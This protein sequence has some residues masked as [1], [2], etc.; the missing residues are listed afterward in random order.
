MSEIND[1]ATVTLNVNGAQAKRMMSELETKI[2]QTNAK[3]SS[4]KANMADPKDIEKAR[5]DLKTYQTQL[6]E[7][8]SAAAGVTKAL[9]NLDAATPR[10]IE[11]ALR[12]LNRQLKDMTPGTDVWN[13]HI[14]KIQVLK[15]RLADLK[16]GLETQES[17]WMKFR[18]W[19]VSAWPA[20]DILRQ[21]YEKLTGIVNE[22]VETYATMDSAMANTQKFT[23]MTRD[24]VESLNEEFKKMDTRTSREGLNELAQSAGRLGKQ[25]VEDVMGF[26]R[27]GDII[28]V[29]MDEL[30]S[31]APEI[32]SKLAGIFN[33]ES[34]M[35]TEK[36]ML[37]VG[38]AINSLTQ[39]YAA[40]AP[41]LVDFA[42]RMGAT[43]SQTNM[44]MHEML[45]FGTLLDANGVS[46]EKSAT[47][48]QGVISKMYATPKKFA[49][50]AGLDVNAFTEAL[51]RSSTEGVLMFVEALSK[52]DQMQLNATLK[53]LKIS[54]S[55]IT[56][57]F[58]TLA[59]KSQDLNRVLAES[60]TAFNQATSATEEY[61][62]Q[63]N[64]AQAKLDKIKKR[65]HD[66]QVEIGEKLY[67]LMGH[68]M[69]SASALSKAIL[70]LI[71]FM[72]ANKTA[73]VSLTAGVV[74]YYIAINLAAVKTAYFNVVSKAMTAVLGLQ[75]LGT[76]AMTGVIGLFTG[77]ITKATAAFKLFSTAIKAN[78]IGLIVSA[79]TTAIAALSSWIGKTNEAKRAEAEAAK[80]RAEAMNTFRREI[81]DYSKKASDYANGE[82]SRL[83]KLYSA[84][85]DATLSQKDRLAA[86]KRLQAAYPAT[87]ANL[88]NEEILT[89]RASKS[90]HAL[91]TNIMKVAKAKAAADLIKDNEKLLLDLEVENDLLIESITSDSKELDRAKYNRTLYG[92]SLSRDYSLSLLGPPASAKETLNRMDSVVTN[93]GSKIDKAGET[94]E[95]NLT[96]IGEIRD[97]N[98]RLAKKAESA[99]KDV[100]DV[101]FDYPTTT[102]SALPQSEAD[103][104]KAE[105]EARRAEAKAKKE[106][107]DTIDSY[108]AQ[109]AA[110]D[111]AT[112]DQHKSGVLDYEEYI[113][114]L[115]QNEL[116]YFD[117]SIAHFEETF[118]NKKETYLNDD[119]DY[120]QLL[121]DRAKSDERY[122][123]RYVSLRRE[124]INREKAAKELS[125]QHVF[126]TKTNP[127]LEDEIKLQADLYAIRKDALEKERDLYAEGSK[128]RADINLKIEDQAQET[129]LAKKKLYFKAV[130]AIRQEYDKKSAAERFELEKAALDALLKAG[131]IPAEK[132]A[133]YLKALTE[134]YKAELPGSK[135][136]KWA[137]RDESKYK[138][139]VDE[140]KKALDSKLLSQEAY[141]DKMNQLDAERR[142]KML[143]GLK[144]TGGEW[145]AMLVDV[146]T[147]FAALVDGFDGSTAN[148][149]SN[150][151]NCVAAVSAMVSSG[152]Q[153]ATEFA[154]AESEIQIA[155]IEKRYDKEIQLAQGNSYKVS[156]LEKQKEAE[157]AK[158]KNK[159]S[160]KQFQMQVISAI[161]QSLIAGLNAYSSTAAIPVVGPFLA[162][163]AMAVALAMGAVQVAL[164]K[165]QQQA[166]EAQGYSQGGFTK[167]GRV[168]EPAG[169]VHAG[170]WVASQKLLASP[171]ARPMI[172]ALDYAQRTNTV[173][174]LRAEDVSR[175]IRAHD[176]LA[177]IAESDGTSALVAAAVAQ[178]AQAV[179]ALNA[180]LNEPFITVNTV[181]GDRGIKAAQDEY[182]RL[183]NNKS[184]K[185]RRNAV[186]R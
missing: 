7:M 116:Q 144:E 63:N 139:D 140:L 34:E 142:E 67:P 184:P 117:K 106:F 80:Q 99:N 35:G 155:A 163:A 89:G 15:K 141:N 62:V 131:V 72:S 22:Y 45:A 1:T 100:P 169:I 110:A 44:A 132:Y 167:P 108:K 48:L 93:L 39:S 160:K 43:A 73:I 75:R 168:D 90:Y 171:V 175:S 150:V 146:Y 118:K 41:S 159:A 112:L 104:K 115:H 56:Q 18:T 172:E 123:E 20:F 76:I 68:L 21:G 40:S 174:S 111:L 170:E 92:Q 36:A 6:D 85:Q 47:A 114:Q 103:R 23:G 65:F 166:A 24:Q 87:F 49:E 50:Q 19:S 107:K 61:N 83:K 12:T 32:I 51:K 53:E 127:T 179:I 52:M 98:A 125:A 57:T 70:M 135:D 37:S 58:Q 77:N 157:I 25:S 105:A 161:A 165:K 91:A 134:K 119:K 2:E 8:K 154:K 26:V 151:A 28:G 164:L 180:R 101:N 54:G 96:K 122:V 128:E 5:K 74:S 149:L 86:I 60:K 120:Q 38:S 153:I 129:D 173:G 95:T 78:P 16:G 59:G 88:S 145:N 14:E 121:L 17:V 177:R 11:R 156:K 94:Y 82:L 136:T 31:D 148:T 33:L 84:T 42:N 183:I 133:E 126:D 138:Q 102:P 66:L 147:S 9:D 124:A 3:I 162:P 69:T 30:G 55:G 178:N 29:A 10:Q 185:Y 181:T 137:D 46:V 143:A 158:E 176:S 81:S 182:T 109:K 79:I 13:S 152:M 71:N 64:T 97:V 113:T 27:A 186:G 130:N 4:L